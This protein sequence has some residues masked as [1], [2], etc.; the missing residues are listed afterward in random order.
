MAKKPATE[1]LK[2]RIAVLE[3]KQAEEGK[4]FKEELM[5]V[6]ESLRPS[7]LLKTTIK[8]LTSS[9][10][11]KKTLFESVIVLTNGIITKLL[12]TSTK[13]STIS[14]LLTTLLQLGVT[15]LLANRREDIFQF[16]KKWSNK[17]F[18]KEEMKEEPTNPSGN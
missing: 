1:I 17:L 4:A 5:A 13:G 8:D 6:Y 18:S 14:K 7:N 12:V 15:N 2:E 16:F 9:T 3:T 10:E 11:L